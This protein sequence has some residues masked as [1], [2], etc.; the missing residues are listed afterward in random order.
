MK[1]YFPIDNINS[2]HG[3]QIT[4][5]FGGNAALY[6]QFGLAGHNGWDIAAPKG[7]PIYAAQDAIS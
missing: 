5:R 6:A 1:L 2:A 4:Q 7:T 3:V